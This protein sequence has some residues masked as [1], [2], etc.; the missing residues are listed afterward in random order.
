MDCLR[1]G[2]LPSDPWHSVGSSFT[3]VLHRFMSIPTPHWFPV[4]ESSPIPRRWLRVC[5]EE[6]NDS[7]S[8]ASMF[9]SGVLHVLLIVALF[10]ITVGSGTGTGTGPMANPAIRVT[11]L[12]PSPLQKGP[13][14]TKRQ[15]PVSRMDQKSSEPAPDQR[16]EE[17]IHPAAVQ[18]PPEKKKPEPSRPASP[19][20]QS[21]S[22]VRPSPVISRSAARPMVKP[23]QSKR[24]TPERVISAPAVAGRSHAAP[25]EG[26]PHLSK[27]GASPPAASLAAAGASPA[28]AG[29]TGGQRRT[30]AGR[31]AP[32]SSASLPSPKSQMGPA[33][34]PISETK[35]R[36]LVNSHPRFRP[37]GSAAAVVAPS[38]AEPGLT[39]ILGGLPHPGATLLPP[40]QVRIHAE[41]MMLGLPRGEADIMMQVG[42]GNPRVLRSHGKQERGIAAITGSAPEHVRH[43]IRRDSAPGQAQAVALM[44]GAG[45]YGDPS[46]VFTPAPPAATAPHIL[47]HVTPLKPL[48][49]AADPGDGADIPSRSPSAARLSARDSVSSLAHDDAT[50]EVSHPRNHSP[51]KADADALS[52]SPDVGSEDRA[53]RLAPADTSARS[54]QS[55]SAMAMSRGSGDGSKD[56]D[57]PTFQGADNGRGKTHATNPDPGAGIKA[58]DDDGDDDSTQSHSRHRPGHPGGDAPANAVAS[59]SRG[60]SD[61][62]SGGAVF[63]SQKRGDDSPDTGDAVGTALPGEGG[64][65]VDR[66]AGDGNEPDGL[67]HAAGK[68]RGLYSSLQGRY[69][70]RMAAWSGDQHFHF[71]VLDALLAHIRSK[72]DIDVTLSQRFLPI[73][74]PKLQEVPLLVFSGITKFKLS[75]PEREALRQYV[76]RGG[77]IWGDE[78]HIPAFDA[79][80]RK[81]MVATFG[82]E[83]DEVELSDPVNHSRYQLSEIPAGPNGDRKPLLGIHTDSGRWAVIMTPNVYLNALDNYDDDDAREAALE[84]GTNIFC[85]AV[86]N[87]QLVHPI[88]E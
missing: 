38:S 79:S 47:A 59:R 80:F 28:S 45:R 78:S 77:M 46:A 3:L 34:T 22:A 24:S 76:A 13:P 64:E 36:V 25:T 82:Q 61:D 43:I 73:Q 2:A 19:V 65:G 52:A 37:V 17:Q 42:A 87:Y 30:N 57:G 26:P 60:D 33:A 50:G 67:P 83:P 88:G 12:P 86:K 27:T 1:R 6:F 11:F 54:P 49:P 69:T 70:M 4:V 51:K 14:V 29:R 63:G 9:A 85:Y 68:T 40:R 44:Q 31:A 55:V 62:D 7:V 32:T 75:E 48:S 84:V 81:E 71:R 15:V 21:Q 56:V 35:S 41:N 58:G 5:R 66:G 74:D 72:T 23:S 53:G 39:P 10:F 8:A 18:P 16:V 20:T